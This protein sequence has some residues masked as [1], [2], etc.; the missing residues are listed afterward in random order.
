M[1][2]KLL[3]QGVTVETGITALHLAAIK[4]DVNIVSSLMDAGADYHAI[5]G[6]GLSPLHFVVMSKVPLVV[7]ALLKAGAHV[8]AR[9][10]LGMTVLMIA[11]EKNVTECIRSLLEDDGIDINITDNRGDSALV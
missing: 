8:N 11:I 5:G 6:D 1:L 4:G 3:S 9:T 10:T 7:A 2:R